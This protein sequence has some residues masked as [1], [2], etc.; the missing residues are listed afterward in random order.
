[1]HTREIGICAGENQTLPRQGGGE[2]LETREKCLGLDD[3]PEKSG[4]PRRVV[5]GELEAGIRVDGGEKPLVGAA[6]VAVFVESIASDV[7]EGRHFA[8]VE[9]PPQSLRKR[10]SPLS[11]GGDLLRALG[12]A[13]STLPRLRDQGSL[14]LSGVHAKIMTGQS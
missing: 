10:A 11:L 9:T 8:A 5:E 4:G 7:G 1:M 6:E 13:G 2:L 12:A 14:G 3:M